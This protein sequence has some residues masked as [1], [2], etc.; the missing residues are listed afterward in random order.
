MDRSIDRL[1]KTV[2]LYTE[3]EQENGCQCARSRGDESDREEDV[4]VFVYV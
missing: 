4:Q 3:K 1:I 2:M